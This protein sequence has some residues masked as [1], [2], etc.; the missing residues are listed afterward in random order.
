[1]SNYSICNDDTVL[2]QALALCRG[3]YQR[4]ILLGTE[5]LSG[6]TLRGKAREYGGRYRASAASILVRCQ[7]AGL[8][9]REEIGS[10]GKRL[11]VIGGAA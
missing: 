8:A 5:A 10:H 3:R 4:N 6:S 2:T 9:V 1:M 7:Q 11:V